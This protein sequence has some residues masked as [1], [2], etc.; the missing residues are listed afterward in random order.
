[1]K[2]LFKPIEAIFIGILIVSCG[3]IE[4]TPILNA[5]I[6]PTHMPVSPT[7]TISVVIPSSTPSIT[8]TNTTRPY[9]D[10]AGLQMAYVIDGSIYFQKGTDEPVQLTSGE[11]D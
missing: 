6:T 9:P 2:N 3:R 5:A 8:P 11:K 10:L 4:A 1:M 7:N